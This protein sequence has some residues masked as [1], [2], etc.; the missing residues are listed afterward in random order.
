MRAANLDRGHYTSP[1][2]NSQASYNVLFRGTSGEKSGSCSAASNQTFR[3][4]IIVWRSRWGRR[5][6]LPVEPDFHRSSKSRKSPV[7]W[8][9]LLRTSARPAFAALASLAVSF[10]ACRILGAGPWALVA[11]TLVFAASYIVCW[12]L[13]PAGLALL[14][15]SLTIPNTLAPQRRTPNLTVTK[16]RP[17][18]LGVI[19][20]EFFDPRLGPMGGFGWA[21][22]S[23]V[24]GFQP[25]FFG[26]R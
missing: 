26:R 10:A 21:A 8:T 4:W 19:A 1:P 3:W 7:A 6:R 5:F 9:D 25:G 13:I 22:R 2:F 17:I 15:D 14:R 16:R 23:L 24:E 20:S 12:M 18:R 11:N